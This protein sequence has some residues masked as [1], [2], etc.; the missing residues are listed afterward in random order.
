MRLAFLAPSWILACSEVW[1]DS[2]ESNLYPEVKRNKK[3][4]QKNPIKVLNL[5]YQFL[6]QR[7]CIIFS[8]IRG[9]RQRYLWVVRKLP[10]FFDELRGRNLTP[11]AEFHMLPWEGWL[12]LCP[13][14]SVKLLGD[15]NNSRLSPIL[16]PET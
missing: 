6:F 10:V 4:K 15:Q 11:E 12:P 3:K 13:S 5:K 16:G 7:K 14:S 9:F 2:H 8:G 1:G